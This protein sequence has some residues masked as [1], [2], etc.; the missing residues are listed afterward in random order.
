M[1]ISA[2]IYCG[3]A[4][5]EEGR[6]T[7]QVNATRGARPGGLAVKGRLRAEAALLNL[8]CKWAQRAIDSGK[9]S[10]KTIARVARALNGRRVRGGKRL[11]LSPDRL[12]THLSRWRKVQSAE[13]FPY[14]LVTAHGGTVTGELKRA[15]LVECGAPEVRT[16]IGAWRVLRASYG[17][18]RN[19]P[20]LDSFRRALTER[21]RRELRR[22]FF[23]RGQ[24]VRAARRFRCAL[25][26]DVSRIMSAIFVPLRTPAVGIET[27]C[28][29]TGETEKQIRLGIE[30]GRLTWAW[31]VSIKG[32]GGVIRVLA[33]CV[34]D[35][36]VRTDRLTPLTFEQVVD[37]LLGGGWAVENPI[38][39]STLATGLNVER[40]H[41]TKLTE[42]GALQ[43]QQHVDRRCV[44][45]VTRA[46]FASFLEARRVAW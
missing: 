43:A 44:G 11:R 20:S 1:S 39:P 14:L 38:P 25:L 28:A 40:S 42:V 26:S 12:R 4:E 30:N 31:D 36:F 32:N 18:P 5:G 22:L 9:P 19:F 16:L 15:L 8:G 17:A 29:V 3:S 27:I 46:D 34:S 21:D 45:W 6:A 33:R 23:A 7:G 13:A 41:I 35:L 37:E 2:N 10:A 24:E